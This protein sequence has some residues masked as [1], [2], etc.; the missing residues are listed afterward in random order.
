M[1][2]GKLNLVSQNSNVEI[3]IIN[4]GIDN[5]YPKF[6]FLHLGLSF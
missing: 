6:S 5:E 1:T 4:I 2:A 3:D